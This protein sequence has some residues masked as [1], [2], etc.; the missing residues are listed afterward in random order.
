[1]KRYLMLKVVGVV[2]AVAFL[3]SVFMFAGLHGCTT[4]GSVATSPSTIDWSV[5]SAYY[6]KYVTGLAAIGLGVAGAAY[7]SAAPAIAIAAKEVANLNDLL[8][9]KASDA[10]MQQQLGTVVKAITDADNKFVPVPIPGA[11][12]NPSSSA[13]VPTK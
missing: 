6:S 11:I 8:V 4:T 13:P 10:T 1:M 9:A 2:L 5:T 7:P 12:A 3:T